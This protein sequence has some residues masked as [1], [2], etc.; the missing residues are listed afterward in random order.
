VAETIGI[1]NGISSPGFISLKSMVVKII[2]VCFAVAGGLCGGK[3]GPLIHI[4]AIVGYACAYLPLGINKYFRNDVELRKLLAVGTA[5]GVS[6]AFG[7]PIG[8]ALFAYELSKPNSFWSFSLT[9]KVFFASSVSTF[10]LS[11]F[12]QLFEG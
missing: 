7:A 8:G 11:V 1:L 2:G 5:A 10:T 12:K 4:G 6:T 3:E 9:W